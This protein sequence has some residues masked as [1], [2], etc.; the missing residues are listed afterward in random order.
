MIKRSNTS[1]FLDC[2]PRKVTQ[3]LI[4]WG[5]ESLFPHSWQ[6]IV[7]TTSY[8][9]EDGSTNRR[10]NGSPE[11]QTY[12][13]LPLLCSSKQTFS[14]YPR[15]ITPHVQW[16]TFCLWMYWHEESQMTVW[17]HCL[18]SLYPQVKT[19]QLLNSTP[20]MLPSLKFQKQW[21]TKT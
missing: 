9:T 1:P 19:F 15:L 6:G 4:Q 8:F 21:S 18:G 10:P 11:S 16:F 3:I 5:S 17:H 14:R 13:S 7:D 12:W 2:L 20:V